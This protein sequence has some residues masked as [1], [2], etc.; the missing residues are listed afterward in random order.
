[1]GDGGGERGVNVPLPA[2]EDGEEVT[3]PTESVSEA[4]GEGGESGARGTYVF[5]AYRISR[6]VWGPRRLPL[7]AATAAA[8][9]AGS[10][11]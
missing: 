9:W 6:R 7:R 4:M 11:Y 8:A 3:D 2:S 5:A 1:M 10:W